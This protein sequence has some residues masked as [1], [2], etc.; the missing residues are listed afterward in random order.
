MLFEKLK[1][2]GAYA[3]TPELKSDERGFFGRLFCE[4]EFAAYGLETRYVQVNNSSSTLKGTLR[5]LHYQ[6][7]PAE[8]TKLV[9]CIRGEIWDVVLDLRPD[10]STYGQWDAVTLTEENRIMMYVPEGCAHGFLTLTENTEV[11]YLVSEFYSSSLERGVRWDDP[12]FNI[13]WPFTPT[14]I[15][16]RDRQHELTKGTFV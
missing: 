3:I 1:V 14:T 10:S 13:R 2:N 7:A 9:R 16:D 12:A 4:K 11:I 8:E 6:L 5:G 15:S